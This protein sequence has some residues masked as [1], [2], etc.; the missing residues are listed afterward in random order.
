M[1]KAADGLMTLFPSHPGLYRW[2]PPA[3]TRPIHSGSLGLRCAVRQVPFIPDVAFSRSTIVVIYGDEHYWCTER[4]GIE[5]RLRKS[6]PSGWV[7][8]LVRVE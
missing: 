8:R 5:E 6:V 3:F 4:T 1:S 7:R 2:D